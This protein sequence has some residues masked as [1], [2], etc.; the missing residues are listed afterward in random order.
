[1]Q[2]FK[3]GLQMVT[4][5]WA[6]RDK[7]FN[8]GAVLTVIKTYRYMVYVDILLLLTTVRGEAGRFVTA[9]RSEAVKISLDRRPEYLIF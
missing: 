7:R 8:C 9:V 4:A 6:V 5:V 3:T 1:M 2:W